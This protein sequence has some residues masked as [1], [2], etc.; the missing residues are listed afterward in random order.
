[1][2]IHCFSS[3]SSFKSLCGTVVGL[4]PLAQRGGAKGCGCFMVGGKGL[5]FEVCFA[6]RFLFLQ[7]EVEEMRMKLE[8]ATAEASSLRKENEILKAEINV[9]RVEAAVRPQTGSTPA[10]SSTGTRMK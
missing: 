7:R 8:Q 5:G 9:A 1:M 4:R 10:G 3:F 6:L 2:L